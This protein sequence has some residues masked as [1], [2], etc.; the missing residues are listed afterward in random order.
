MRARWDF[1]A[2]HPAIFANMEIKDCVAVVT[3]A[4]SAGCGGAIAARFASEGAIVVVSDIDEDGGRATVGRIERQGGAACFLRADVR[5]QRDVRALLDFAERGF[6]GL[7]VLVNNASA[8]FRPGQPL[9]HWSEIIE[10]DLLGAMYATRLAIE[11]MRRGGGGTII[12]VSSTSAL[13]HGRLHS[14]SSPAYDV[15]KAGVLRL[16]TML[17]SLGAEEN[18]RVNCI[19]PD[20]VATPHVRGYWDALT[21]DQRS[22]QGIPARLTTVEEIASAVLRLVTDDTLAGRALV[23]WSDDEPRLI[24][25]GDPGYASLELLRSDKLLA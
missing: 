2:F 18:I 5:D 21:P 6:G 24:P 12:N 19:V 11:A 7:H 1:V 16:T 10:T 13:A 3:G 4:G 23:W 20:W 22:S 25:W 15:A 14:G 17:A 9:E 8:P